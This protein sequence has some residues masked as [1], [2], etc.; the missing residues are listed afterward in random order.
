MLSSPNHPRSLLLDS[1][2][3]FLILLEL[4]SPELDTVLQM[5]PHQGK[6]EGEKNLPP[7][8]GH[9]LLHAPH[10]LP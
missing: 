10:C 5:G 4:G 3:Y 8:A 2:Q 6:V 7:P 9:T 1:L